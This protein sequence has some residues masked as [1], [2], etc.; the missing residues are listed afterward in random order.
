M[1]SLSHLIEQFHR[2]GFLVVPNAISR[3]DTERLRRGVERAFE[4]PSVV[5]NLYGGI[6]TMWRPTMF[7]QG[8]EFVQLEIASTASK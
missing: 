8:E 2:D 3:E 5:A 7:E 6:A 1:S 4:K